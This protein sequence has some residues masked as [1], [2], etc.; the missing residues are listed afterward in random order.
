MG[1]Q[2]GTM[3]P[4]LSTMILVQAYWSTHNTRTNKRPP[5]QIESCR[6]ASA[7]AGGTGAGHDA[8]VRHAHA[9][10]NRAQRHARHEVGAGRVARQH[11]AA[12]GVVLAQVT[13]R[14]REVL[15]QVSCKCDLPRGARART[16]A[17]TRTLV[18]KTGIVFI[19]YCRSRLRRIAQ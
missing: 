17:R 18:V 2:P 19:M 9:R 3:V 8:G 11:L 14:G 16:R 12:W 15:A 4:Y 13:V 1:T 7:A 5:A 10:L 6:L